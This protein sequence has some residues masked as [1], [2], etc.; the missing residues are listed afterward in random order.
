MTQAFV[1]PYKTPSPDCV[2]ARDWHD[3]YSSEGARLGDALHDWAPGTPVKL[4]RRIAV[5]VPG[6]LKACGLPSQTKLAL[7]V[8]GVCSATTLRLASE[9][10]QLGIQ[11]TLEHEHTLK[12]AL[13]GHDLAG[14]LSI[15]T[16]LVTHQWVK[17]SPIIP[18]RPGLVLWEDEARVRLEG[19]GSRFPMEV[20]DFEKFHHHDWPSRAMWKLDWDPDELEE[21]VLGSIRLFLNAGHPAINKMLD[22]RGS[23]SS[24]ITRDMI[25]FGVGRLMILTALKNEDFVREPDV[26]EDETV[27]G[28]LR[29]LVRSFARTGD[30]IEVVA[31]RWRK[32]PIQFEAEL[33]ARLE[34]LGGFE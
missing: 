22:A 14:S 2:R 29:T 3:F 25:R 20:V 21:P 8:L 30:S 31:S 23:D 15:H 9:P 19:S 24:L 27:G 5:D 32:D 28:M 10:L 11:S 4:M 34:I 26:Y 1:A 12:L 33:Q 7:V 17:E 16:R 13:D 18:W 6:V